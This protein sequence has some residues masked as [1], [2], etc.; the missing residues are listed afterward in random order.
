MCG[1]VGDAGI[2]SGYK[3]HQ[4]PE[5]E[6]MNHAS[7]PMA[8]RLERQSVDVVAPLRLV[9]VRHDVGEAEDSESVAVYGAGARSYPRSR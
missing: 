7:A 8:F 6:P 9:I 1:E 2:R 5:R 3:P 4:S